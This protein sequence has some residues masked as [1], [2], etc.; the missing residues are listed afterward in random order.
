MK[1]G[2]DKQ[3]LSRIENISKNLQDRAEILH[4]IIEDIIRE[5]E[6][7]EKTH[8]KPNVYYLR[9]HISEALKVLEELEKISENFESVKQVLEELKNSL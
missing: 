9:E 8:S 3:K 2:F 7:A 6:W 4:A 1:N 5:F